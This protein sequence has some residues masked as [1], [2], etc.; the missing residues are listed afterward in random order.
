[1][2]DKGPALS[3]STVRF[4]SLV[5]QTFTLAKKRCSWT[6]EYALDNP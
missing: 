6:R 2:V 4:Q 1:M 5:P 3:D